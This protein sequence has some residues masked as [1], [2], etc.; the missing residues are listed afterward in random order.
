MT[1]F[2][3]LTDIVTCNLTTLLK[4]AEDPRA[5]LAQIIQEMRDGVAG[6]QRSAA[7]AARN[8]EKVDTEISEQ[9]SQI[10]YWL[11]DARRH[12]ADHDE[13]AARQALV[14]KKDVEA[15]IA[16]LEQQ[17][18][19][20]RATRDHLQTTLAAL[21]AR[22]HDAERRLQGIPATDEHAPKSKTR[23]S[24][25]H[26]SQDQLAEIDRELAELRREMQQ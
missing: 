21:K 2:S 15:L 10:E 16:G 13:A 1:Y 7:T 26:T 6:A 20:A 3:R 4:E 11:A 12:L 17:R 9:Q 25:S 18:N 14:R 5:T 19:A 22:L 23:G 24:D 8:L